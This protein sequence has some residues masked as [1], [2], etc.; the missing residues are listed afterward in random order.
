MG[1]LI[2]WFIQAYRQFIGDDLPDIEGKKV[3]D[4]IRVFLTEIT[5]TLVIRKLKYD[6]PKAEK[7]FR[8]ID[9]AITKNMHLFT[10]FEKYLR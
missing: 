9:D 4:V 1:K 3:N 7:E 6:P 10:D 2:D 8:I 5:E